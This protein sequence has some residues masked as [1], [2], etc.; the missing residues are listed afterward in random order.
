MRKRRLELPATLDYREEVPALAITSQVPSVKRGQE[1]AEIRQETQLA[2]NRRIVVSLYTQGVRGTS[3]GIL[4]KVH[5]NFWGAVNK[6]I[7]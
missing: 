6:T 1:L 2:A 4:G 3:T 7:A 5:E